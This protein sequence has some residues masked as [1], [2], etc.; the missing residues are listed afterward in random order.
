LGGGLLVAVTVAA[1]FPALD[2]GFIWDDDQYVSAN[3]AL[4]SLDG[5]R[6]I[7]LEPG[8]VPQ[9]YPLTFTSFWVEYQL[10]GLQP[11]GYHLVNV[12]LHAINALLLWLV[13]RR[14]H[15]PGAWLAA[16]IFALHPMQVE[17]VAWITERKNVLAGVFFFSA[18]LVYLK[19]EAADGAASPARIRWR[20][21]LAA[22]ALFVGALLSK[23]VTCS[24]PA[25]LL[26]VIWRQ[27]G[28]IDRRAVLRL[29]PL[30][31][32]GLVMAAVTVWVE[33]Y[34]VGA[35]GREFT[36]S[37][38]ERSLVAG[39]ALWFYPWTLVWPDNLAFIYPRWS[40]DVRVWW[41]YLFPAA[42]LAVI[43]LLHGARRRIGTG[44]LVA[45][46]CYAGALTPALGLINVYPM[47]YSFVADHFA[48]F[49]IVA[50][51]ALGTAAGTRLVGRVGQARRVVGYAIGAL[52][53]V[54][55]ALLTARQCGIYRD[56]RALWTDTLAK[57]PEAWMAH[58]NLGTLLQEQDRD[59]DG[60]I[61]R[62][63]ESL[64]LNPGNAEAH[65]NLGT[66]LA[67]KGELEA[68]VKAYET[69][70]RLKPD[71]PGAHYNLGLALMMKGGAEEAIGHYREALRFRPAYAEA[72]NNLGV[73]LALQ[74]KLEE[75]I[76][77]F[78]Q[79]LRFKSNYPSA[80]NNLGSALQQ[81]GRLEEAIAQ[82]E[83]A[84]RLLPT[85]DQARDNLRAALAARDHRKERP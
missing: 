47:R 62:Y 4:R 32:V 79:A 63:A 34:H 8:A 53:L 85:Y 73:A 71:L 2:N 35:Q 30:F 41:Q 69:A 65:I 19:A 22:C 7:W 48:Y 56:L 43:V 74:G 82:F 83:D 12:L 29:A 26:L 31:A 59:F 38:L 46:L 70:L 81:T 9:Y 11:F 50:L 76:G 72:H 75:A 16:A 84:V 61:A 39:R 6:R 52:I 37:L 40:I 18:F 23:T 67:A 21:Y 68:A 80:H 58:N 57:N 64:R 27:R 28:A 3:A 51:I 25:V 17:S 45:G 14:L 49:P 24:L 36:L 78:T 54:V 20:P 66:A 55:L 1:Y 77:H 33:R 42:A 15:L 5:L 60:A 44:P 13:L 10:W